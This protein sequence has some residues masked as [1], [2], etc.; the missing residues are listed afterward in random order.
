[1]TA[2]T[3]SE[4]DAVDAEVKAIGQEV[5]GRDLK[6]GDTIWY[7]A[8]RHYRGPDFK[9]EDCYLPAV[10]IGETRVSWVASPDKKDWLKL[11]FPKKKVE[12]E[13]ISDPDRRLATHGRG[14][15]RTHVY[16]TR[17]AIERDIWLAKNRQPLRQHLERL[18]HTS[19]ADMLKKVA[20]L[21]G[22]TEVA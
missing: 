15:G 19:D 20:A 4:L 22:Y 3:Q 5:W 7:Y 11:K 2:P 10:I 8:E 16:L 12:G 1:M 6:V 13:Y 18:V 17:E 9:P 14:D 21:T